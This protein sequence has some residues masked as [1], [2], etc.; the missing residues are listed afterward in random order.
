M[1]PNIRHMVRLVHRGGHFPDDDEF[2]WD[3]D[4]GGYYYF[5]PESEPRN[6]AWSDGT[7]SFVAIYDVSGAGDSMTFKVRIPPIHVDFSNNSGTE[8]GSA[9]FPFKFLTGGVNTILEPPRSIR[10][11]GG[12]YPETLTID[13]PCTIAHWKGGS[14]VVGG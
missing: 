4:E 6:S 5:G 11:A 12:N 3:G 7:P 13:T 10:I 1:T 2:L 9:E 8:T 14:A